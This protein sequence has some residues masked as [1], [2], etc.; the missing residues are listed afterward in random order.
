MLEK[1]LAGKPF[2]LNATHPA[3]FWIRVLA[4]L[5]DFLVLLVFG[6]GA[7]FMKSVAGYILL[8]IPLILYKPLLEGILGGIAGKLAIGLRVIARNTA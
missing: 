4:Y 7:L 3:G 2:D 5:I 1:Y 8:M 6:V